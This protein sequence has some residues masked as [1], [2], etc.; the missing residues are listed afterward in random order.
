MNKSLLLIYTFRSFPYKDIVEKLGVEI[1]VLDKLKTD[2]AELMNRIRENKPYLIVGFAKAHGKTTT[3]EK[4]A[5]N[6]FH[7]NS[8]VDP[9]VDEMKLLMDL[10]SKTVYKIRENPTDSYCNYSM[11][12]IRRLLNYEHLDS[13]FY[14]LHVTETDLKRIVRL[15]QLALKGLS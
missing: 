9:N 6:Q 1:Y 2:L 12:K 14:F 3:I 15:F 11:Y 8:K 13:Q 4:Y 7:K 10:P 5:I